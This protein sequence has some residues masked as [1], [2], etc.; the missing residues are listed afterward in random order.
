[1]HTPHHSTHNH[2]DLQVRPF[3]NIIYLGP[4]LV[5]VGHFLVGLSF[6]AL[7]LLLRLG[8]AL[9]DRRKVEGSLE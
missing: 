8:L 6:F 4:P 1:M 3:P 5:H 7:F 2:T 9:H